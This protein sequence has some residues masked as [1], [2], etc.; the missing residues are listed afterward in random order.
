MAWQSQGH[1]QDTWLAARSP[2]SQKLSRV[3]TFHA[4]L[5]STPCFAR[6]VLHIL[7]VSR[8]SACTLAITLDRELLALVATRNLLRKQMQDAF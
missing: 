3:E 1:S 8:P 5:A 2:P 4:I 6:N 7:H